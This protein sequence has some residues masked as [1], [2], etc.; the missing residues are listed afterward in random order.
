CSV[1]GCISLYGIYDF[2][3][4]AQNWKN[5]LMGWFLK[6]FVMPAPL[7]KDPELWDRASPTRCIT[8]DAPPFLVIHGTR[9]VLAPVREARR[10]CDVFRSIAREPIY[11]AEIPGA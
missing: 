6:T 1:S 4:R 10:F 5:P 9:D 11:Y 8:P 3:N 7:E 2:V